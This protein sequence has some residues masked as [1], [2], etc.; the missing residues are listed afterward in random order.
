MRVVGPF[1]QAG[2]D[3][4]YSDHECLDVRYDSGT[5]IIASHDIALGR[6][7]KIVRVRFNT[8]KVLC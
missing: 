7:G 1:G 2:G 3:L 4:S 5:W 8:G 6:V